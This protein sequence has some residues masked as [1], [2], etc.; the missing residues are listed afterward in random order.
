MLQKKKNKA[1]HGDEEEAENFV[2]KG[3]GNAKN[4]KKKR[5]IMVKRGVKHTTIGRRHQILYE[6]MPVQYYRF[7]HTWKKIFHFEGILKNWFFLIFQLLS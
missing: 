2:A 3:S 7:G 6:T 5:W 1:E 4:E